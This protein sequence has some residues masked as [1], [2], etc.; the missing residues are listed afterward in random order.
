MR[1]L[2]NVGSRTRPQGGVDHSARR[3]RTAPR[4]SIRA[5]RRTRMHS[6]RSCRASGGPSARSRA[7]GVQPFRAAPA[8][9]HLADD[10]D[11]VEALE[12]P[13]DPGDHQRVVIGDDHADRA[14]SAPGSGTMLSFC[15]CAHRSSGAVSRRGRRKHDQQYPPARGAGRR[16]GL[17]TVPPCPCELPHASPG[18]HTIAELVPERGMVCCSLTHVGEELLDRQ[19]PRGIRGGGRRWVSRSCFRGP[20]ASPGCVRRGGARQLPDD[21]SRVPQDPGGLPIHGVMPRMMRWAAERRR[22]RADRDAHMAR[23]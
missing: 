11:V 18:G 14:G 12:R 22:V 2:Q 23:T 5:R 21:R 16:A 13:A 20:T 8:L 7:D 15:S 19:G 9:M 6:T 4:P 17:T 10:L 3:M 1:A